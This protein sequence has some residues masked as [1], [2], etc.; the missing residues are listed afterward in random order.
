MYSQYLLLISTPVP[1]AMVSFLLSF[2]EAHG[3]LRMSDD[4]ILRYYM[5]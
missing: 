2:H 4:L 3:E 1:L 5:V